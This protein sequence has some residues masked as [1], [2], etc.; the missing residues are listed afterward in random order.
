[1]LSEPLPGVPMVQRWARRYSEVFSWALAPVWRHDDDEVCYCPRRGTCPTPGKHLVSGLGVAR[2][3]DEAA[4]VWS[5]S[6]E[7]VCADWIGVAALTGSESELLVIDARHAAELLLARF[8]VHKA[9]LVTRTPSGGAH[10]FFRT[11]TGEAVR[12]ARTE[13]TFVESAWVLGDGGFVPLPPCEDYVWQGGAGALTADRLGA[14]PHGLRVRLSSEGLLDVGM[15]DRDT[16]WRTRPG[17]PLVGG[18]PRTY[19]RRGDVRR[20]VDRY[21]DKMLYTPGIGWRV[22]TESGWGG[23]ERSETLLRSYAMELPD[24]HITEAK[25]SKKAGKDSLVK[26]AFKWAERS[27]ERPTMAIVNELQSDERVL[28]PSAEMWDADGRVVGLPVTDGVPRTL[29]LTT[30]EIRTDAVLRLVS[31]TLGVGYGGEGLDYWWARASKFPTFLAGLRKAHGDEWMRLLQRATGAALFGRR[32]VSGDTDAIFV[33][34]GPSRS[35]KS[36][37]AECLLAVAGAYGSPVN[38][39]LLFGSRGNS[40]FLIAAVRGTRVGVLSEPTRDRDKALN[41][42]LL[43]SL[44]G[45]DSQTGRD[46]YG[47]SEVRFTPDVS[48][49]LLTNHALVINDEAVWIRLRFFEFSYDAV[50]RGAAEDPS[51]RAALVSDPTE[52]CC[53]AAWFLEGAKTWASEGWGSTR[54]WDEARSRMKLTASATAMFVQDAVERTGRSLDGFTQY[55]LRIAWNRWEISSEHSEMAKTVNLTEP[56]LLTELVNSTVEAGLAWDPV[57]KRLSGGV[58]K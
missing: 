28:V 47:R 56:A 45:G 53:A 20:L 19:T 51:I 38:E 8:G 13:V 23:V 10:L 4:L 46:P 42:T 12:G 16:P 52:L 25:D 50:H 33:L 1:M 7:R 3:P 2:D 14:L 39:N 40:E 48:L 6:D 55:Q 18:D 54:L 5:A 49:W 26:A 29:D 15:L 32:E 41:E 17:T 44:S 21:G 36:T 58:L 43:K 27:K 34:Q 9:V 24:V 31:K 11:E 57:T 37:L 30:G 35:G 22:W